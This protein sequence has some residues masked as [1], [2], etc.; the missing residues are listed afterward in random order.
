MKSTRQ[1]VHLTFDLDWACD[2]VIAHTLNILEEEDVP[3]TLFVTH[4]TPLLK[5]MRANP[6]LE[7]GAH[8][9]FI[10]LHLGN[11]DISEFQAYTR[12]VLEEYRQLLPEATTLRSHGL[13][14]NTRLMDLIGEMGYT[15]ESNLLIT[16]SSGMNLRPF[17]HW[18]GL[19]RVPYFWED[20][21]HCVE[22]ERKFWDNSWDVAPFLDN[23]CLKVFDFH[24]IHVFLN[25]ESLNRYE[26]ARPHFHNPDI[27]RQL[28]NK[29]SR[30]DEHFLRDLICETRKRGYSFGLMRDIYP[31]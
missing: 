11:C 23:T 30:G 28:A 12:H 3:A 21:I 10:P 5:R 20:D 22:I 2:E 7:L 26:K 9:N 1:I 17:Y 18:N 6:K 24:P 13:T 25:T 19:M 27:L 16:L 8:P 29:G 4:D 14:Q 31:D 15:R